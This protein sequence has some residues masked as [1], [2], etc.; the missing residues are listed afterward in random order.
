[1][2]R[3]TL[4]VDAK[5]VHTPYNKSYVRATSEHDKVSN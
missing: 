5:I 1:M 4:V 2:H 3:F